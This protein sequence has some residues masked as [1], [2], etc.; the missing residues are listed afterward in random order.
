MPF[1]LSMIAV[2]RYNGILAGVVI[3]STPNA[4]SNLLGYENRNLEKLISRGACISWS[5]KNLASSLIMFSIRWMVQN[6]Q[7]RYF[8]AY[9]DTEAMELGTIYQACNFTYLGKNSGARYK[10]FDPKNPDKG[11]FT[12]RVFRQVRYYK[13]YAKLLGIKWQPNWSNRNSVIWENVPVVI[14]NELRKFS[15]AYQGLCIRKKIPRKHKYVYILGA[16]K[17]ETKQLKRLLN[18]HNPELFKLNYPKIRGH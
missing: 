3:M 18:A 15:K 7:F 9:S 12:D 6:T 11:W 4:F 1:P 2:A 17:R 5:P 13:R 10:Y 16:D 8:T 14:A